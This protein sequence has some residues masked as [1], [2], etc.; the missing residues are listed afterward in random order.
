MRIIFIANPDSANTKV[1]V[2]WF[3][4]RGHQVSL[5]SDTY[6]NINWP[7]MEI[8]DLPKKFNIRTIRYFL[9]ELWIRKIIKEWHPDILHAHRVSSAGWLGSF[10]GFHPFVVTPWGSDLFLHP[11]RSYIAH[12]LANIVLKNADLITLNSK[13]LHQKAIQLGADPNLCQFVSWGVDLNIFYPSTKTTL[14]KELG[15][16]NAPIILSPRAV[17]PLY[18]LDVIIESIPMVLNIFPDAIYLI[19]SY[20]IDHIYKDKLEKRI[21]EL[22][23]NSS[24]QWVP[25]QSSERYVDYFRISNAVISIPSSDSMP[26]TVLEALACGAPVI[27]SDLPSMREIIVDQVNGKIV[28]T[29]NVQAL[30]NATIALLKD[31]QMQASFSRYNTQWVQE[32]AN[33][34]YEM[35]KMESLYQNLMT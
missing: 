20:N 21:N 30:T 28:P 4:R 14:R 9:W 25:F 26:I 3:A 33:R 10:S 18:N 23:I 19:Q 2:N 1:W 32:N 11:E 7:G 16:G 8:Y 35:K 12:K 24:L 17:K 31:P 5:I 29:R 34:D 22:G 15:C 27:V 13:T 6:S